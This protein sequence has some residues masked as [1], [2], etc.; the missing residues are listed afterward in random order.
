M[1]SNLPSRFA[2]VVAVAMTALLAVQAPGA[3]DAGSDGSD[4]DFAPVK[5][6]APWD[7]D[8]DGI[9]TLR[10]NEIIQV[11]DGRTI[12]ALNGIFNWTNVVIP[13][14]VTV[15]FE[16]DRLTSAS[17]NAPVIWRAQTTISVAG[18]LNLNGK[19]RGGLTSGAGAPGG[20]DGSF[21]GAVY[22]GHSDTGAHVGS[23]LGFPLA[24]GTGDQDAIGVNGSGGGGCI[25]L[26]ADESVSITGSITARG[27]DNTQGFNAGGGPGAVRVVSDAIHFS[28]T[29]NTMNGQGGF[30]GQQ[31]YGPVR[32]ESYE[33]TGNGSITGDFTVGP[34]GKVL[35]ESDPSEPRLF[36]DRL[37]DKNGVVT[38]FPEWDPA[39]PDV[40]KPVHLPST[41]EAPFTVVVRAE[42]L[43]EGMTVRIYA[44]NKSRDSALAF[45]G[46]TGQI[47]ASAIFDQSGDFGSREEIN[48]ISAKL[49]NP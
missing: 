13:S 11:S 41:L 39:N 3:Y 5:G 9:V 37:V 40:Y 28:G 49:L 47:E 48:V 21:N 19:F 31:D 12:D 27:A 34:P 22:M 1:S 6:A 7:E 36:V 26:A 30:G 18:T 14:D 25:L 46:D 23:E 33:I 17:I 10:P 45:N 4:G 44:A 16:R 32:F 8:G 24:G 2:F 38:E 42:N 43:P 20:W 35:Y 15:V 29:I